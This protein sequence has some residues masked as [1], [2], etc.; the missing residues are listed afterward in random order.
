MSSS[1]QIPL[2]LAVLGGALALWAL[3]DRLLLPS[4]RWYLKSRAAKV[5]D[6]VRQRL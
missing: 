3:L 2:W 5:L 6:E 1:V 4:V